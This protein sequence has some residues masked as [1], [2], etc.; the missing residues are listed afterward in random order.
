MDKK[1]TRKLIERRARELRDETR[2]LI[3]G[4][5]AKLA[6]HRCD[7][8]ESFREVTRSLADARERLARIEGHLG[9]GSTPVRRT[10]RGHG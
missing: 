10:R 9:V 2:E 5:S 1:E 8:N 3:N 4:V 7:T 6:E